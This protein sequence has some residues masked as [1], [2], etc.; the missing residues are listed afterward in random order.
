MAKD[1]FSGEQPGITTCFASFT[2]DLN[3][4]ECDHGMIA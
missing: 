4:G 3:Q 1:Y 2:V